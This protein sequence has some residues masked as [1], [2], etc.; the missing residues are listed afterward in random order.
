MLGR[1][2]A[3]IALAL[4]AGTQPAVAVPVDDAAKELAGAKARQLF[5]V[6]RRAIKALQ[7]TVAS[8]AFQGYFTAA[9]DVGRSAQLEAIRASALKVQRYFD[10]EE[11]CLID[12]AGSEL[13]RMVRGVPEEHLSDEEAGMVFFEP[14]FALS[15]GEVLVSPV[16]RSP[17]TGRWVLAYVTPIAVDGDNVALLH[18][19]HDLAAMAGDLTDGVDAATQAVIMADET[20]RFLFDSRRPDAGVSPDDGALP[21]TLEG[22]T[23]GDV[24]ARIEAGEP[25]EGYAG[26][27]KKVRGWLVIALQR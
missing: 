20:G 14:G 16:Y 7:S 21:E 5:M 11:M 8:P 19:E 6:H 3:V 18:Y 27:Y 26:S 23:L 25:V 9:D 12:R 4:V 15:A 17:D 2:L 10:V 24:L 1:G 22:L 13:L